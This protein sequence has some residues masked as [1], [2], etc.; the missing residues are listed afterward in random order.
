M[1]KHEIQKLIVPVLEKHNIVKAS[2]FGSFVR[3]EQNEMS[4]IDLLVEFRKGKS[5]LDLISLKNEIEVITKRKTDI[6]TYKSINPMLKES[7]LSEE[8]LIYEERP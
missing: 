2:L 6:L 1:T 8:E 4:D 7:I 3:N 5:L